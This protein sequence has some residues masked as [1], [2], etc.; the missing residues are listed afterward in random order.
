MA[1]NTTSLLSRWRLRSTLDG[2]ETDYTDA[3]G[4]DICDQVIRQ[5]IVPKIIAVNADYFLI[6]VDIAVTSGRYKYPIPSRAYLGKIH[7]MYFLNSSKTTYQLLT[8]TDQRLIGLQQSGSPENHMITDNAIVLGNISSTAGYLRLYYPYRPSAL[9]ATTACMAVTGRTAGKL[10]GTPVG[11]WTTNDKFDVVSGTSPFELIHASLTAS[12]VTGGVTF[13]ESEL[14]TDRLDDGGTYYVTLERESCFPM[15]PEDMHYVL[16]DLASCPV[17]ENIGDEGW[18]DRYQTTMLE[19]ND[20]V[21]ACIMRKQTEF[22]PVL[23]Q[24]SFMRYFS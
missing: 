11:T 17:L 3:V 6:F 21:S 16:A 8:F 12:S 1:F 22:K 4:M 5:K 13:T 20:I 24:F 2:T 9:V 23:N 19:L 18:R 7:S 15:I 10:E 14:D